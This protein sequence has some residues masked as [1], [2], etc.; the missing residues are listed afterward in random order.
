[1]RC[2]A[3]LMLCIAGL[4]ACDT[5][6]SMVLTT[7]GLGKAVLGLTAGE[8]RDGGAEA[9]KILNMQTLVGCSY[10]HRTGGP[11]SD[12]Y[13]MMNDGR[14]VRIDVR[15][16]TSTTYPPTLTAEGVGVG[17]AEGDVMKIYG[18]NLTIEPHK[19][20]ANGKILVVRSNDP[21]RGMIFETSQGK[22][23]SFRAGLYPALGFVEGCS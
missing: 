20:D 12:A 17:S 14:L 10:V 22:V 7:D 18:K 15:K 13:Y 23:T 9:F 11:D 2:T 19:Y 21:A 1:M 5:Q 8:L 4:A 16:S 3:A 6:E